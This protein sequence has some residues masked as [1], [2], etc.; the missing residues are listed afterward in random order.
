[1][2]SYIK[3]TLVNKKEDQIVI[4]CNN[5][6]YR[7]FVPLSVLDA[8]PEVGSLITI[9]TYLHV[10]ED[11]MLLY[12]FLSDEDKEMFKLLINVSGIGPKGALSILSAMTPDELRFAIVSD[13]DK[14]ITKANGI[15]KKIA[16][17]LIIELRDKID[18]S[19]VLTGSRDNDAA[20]AV[21]NSSLNDSRNEAIEALIS[22]GYSSTESF[23]AVS[24]VNI[25]ESMNT[26]DVLKEALKKLAF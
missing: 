11:A 20:M 5:I 16:Q 2:Y 26:E 12:G 17:K 24:N 10:R 3:G 23:K 7:I 4:D 1:M 15:G 19:D 14:A 25:I 22:L 21:N 13:D 9:Y 18:L 8:I 6:G